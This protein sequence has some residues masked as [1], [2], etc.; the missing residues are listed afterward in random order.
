[1]NIEVIDADGG[2][3]NRIVAT[4]ESAEELF[5]G[6]WREEIISIPEKQPEIAVQLDEAIAGKIS[7]IKAE[8]ERRI[9][10]LDWHL[11]RAQERERLG[12][13]GVETVADVLLLREQIRQASNAA[14]LAVST[15]TDVSLVQAFTW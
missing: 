12:E 1:M 2:V 14:E 3:I 4:P 15:L 9:I 8:A 5:P 6:R 13:S 10:A 7:E 11:Q